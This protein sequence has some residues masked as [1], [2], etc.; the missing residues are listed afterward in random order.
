MKTET[1]EQ[2]WTPATLK[3]HQTVSIDHMP[4]GLGWFVVNAAGHRVVAHPG[5]TGTFYVKYADDR[6]SIVLLTN[7]DAGSGSAHVAIAQGI[8]ALLRPEL[9]RFLP[10][11][12]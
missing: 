5:W 3:N 7:L 11:Q 9:P 6:V 12:K 1:L 4:H 8:L 10:E 2:M